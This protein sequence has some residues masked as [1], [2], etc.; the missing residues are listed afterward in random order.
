M[1]PTVLAVLA[2]SA[3]AASVAGPAFACP[4]PAGV[5]RTI[6]TEP[7]TPPPGARVFSGRWR[8]GADAPPAPGWGAPLGYLIEADGD[9]L[10][11]YSAVTSCH[12]DFRRDF[13]DA[14]VWMVGR[15]LLHEG[16]LVGFRARGRGRNGAADWSG[17]RR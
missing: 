17:S 12:A 4:T 8:P 3:L 6:F 9:R 2:A 10:A 15:P 16:R 13:G 1:R 7:Q 5:V 14:E 11:V